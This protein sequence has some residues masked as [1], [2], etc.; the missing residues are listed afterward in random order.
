MVFTFAVQSDCCS[1]EGSA[2]RATLLRYFSSRHLT[3]GHPFLPST[4]RSSKRYSVY[5]YMAFPPYCAPLQFGFKGCIS[6]SILCL[7]SFLDGRPRPHNAEQIWLRKPFPASS[8]DEK[9]EPI[10]GARTD[11]GPATRSVSPASTRLPVKHRPKRRVKKARS[12]CVHTF[13]LLGIVNADEGEPGADDP[14]PMEA[15]S[16]LKL[17]LRFTLP[18]P[19]PPPLPPLPA[20][21]SSTQPVCSCGVPTDCDSRRILRF[22][23]VL[24]EK[25]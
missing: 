16:P 3:V 6:L 14:D 8:T 19:P 15:V 25:V 12:T 22:S 20:S 21:D 4:I 10:K 24:Y 17:A 1:G 13:F 18:L 5:F 2:G 9:Q 23:L 11:V 7:D